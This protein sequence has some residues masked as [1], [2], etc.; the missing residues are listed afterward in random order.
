MQAAKSEE[1]HKHGYQFRFY[2]EK[3]CHKNRNLQNCKPFTFADVKQARGKSL[4]PMLLPA[5]RQV[6]QVETF[7]FTKYR[8]YH[9]FLMGLNVLSCPFSPKNKFQNTP[10]CPETHDNFSLKFKEFMSGLCWKHR[11]ARTERCYFSCR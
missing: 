11:E 9:A 5:Q 6:K 8:N 7:S 4:I 3:Q 1:I 10:I 2:F